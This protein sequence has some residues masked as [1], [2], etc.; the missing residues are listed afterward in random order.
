[1]YILKAV[2]GFI[3]F[4]CHKNQDDALHRGTIRYGEEND[5]N[6]N[7]VEPKYLFNIKL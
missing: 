4:N 1:M 5:A 6:I 7:L 2:E 3:C